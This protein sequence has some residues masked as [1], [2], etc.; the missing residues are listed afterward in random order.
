M[1][2]FYKHPHQYGSTLR[3]KVAKFFQTKRTTKQQLKQ[4][5]KTTLKVV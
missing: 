5:N 1:N 2:D 3:R 4:Q